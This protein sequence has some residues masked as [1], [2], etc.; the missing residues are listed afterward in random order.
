SGGLLMMFGIGSIVGPLIAGVAMT[1]LGPRGLFLTTIGAHVLMIL[2][3]A[4]RISVRAAVQEGEKTPFQIS[5]PARAATPETAA[6]AAGEKEAEPL[7]P[8]TNAGSDVPEPDR[9]TPAKES[10]DK[11]VEEEPGDGPRSA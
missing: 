5:V 2:F 1:E 11:P 4:W 9:E 3:P 10:V 7:A 8:E 6:L